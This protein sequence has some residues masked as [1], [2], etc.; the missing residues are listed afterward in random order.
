MTKNESAARLSFEVFP[1]NTDVGTSKLLTTL[2]ELKSLSPSFI[3]VTCSNKRE[4][5]ENT[6]IK[7]ADYVTN[8]LNIPT[9]AHLPACALNQKQVENI[10]KR[11]AE[12]NINRVL[13][14]RGDLTPDLSTPSDFKYASDLI[15]FIQ[16]TAPDFKISGACYPECHPE[17]QSV[18]SDLHY[19]K[20]KMDAGCQEFI[21]QFFLD[22]ECFYQFQERCALSDINIPILAGIMPIINRKQA[23]RLLK[24]SHTHLPRK[25]VAVLDKYEHNPIAL[26][27]AGL[28]YAIDQIVDLLTQGVSGIHLYTMNNSQTAKAIH[29]ATASLFEEA[30]STH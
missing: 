2:D 4:N 6:T 25:F 24:T 3:S 27:D 20:Q 17:S 12:L 14:L 21:S 19:L 30:C 11:C 1:P 13:A 10:L 18:I 29:A 16:S 8:V 5:I 28:A 23:L 9:V 15:E 26:R 7:V 22:N